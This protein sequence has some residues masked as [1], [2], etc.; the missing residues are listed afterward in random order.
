MTLQRVQMLLE[1]LQ[2]RKLVKLAKLRGKSVAEVTRQVIDM[3]LE[4]M[5][6]SEQQERMLKTLE[7]ARLLR[8]SMPLYDTDLTAELQQM[9]QERDD[10]LARGD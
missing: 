4:Q 9:R 2:H 10:D 8:E 7:E 1:P 3:G 6:V 5:A